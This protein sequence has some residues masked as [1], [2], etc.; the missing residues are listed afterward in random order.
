MTATVLVTTDRDRK[1]LLRLVQRDLRFQAIEISLGTLEQ[2]A[3]T[4]DERRER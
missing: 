1:N 2:I 3:D 4:Y